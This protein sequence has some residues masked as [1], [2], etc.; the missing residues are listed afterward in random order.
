MTGV[1]TC[2]LPIFDSRSDILVYDIGNNKLLTSSLISTESSFETFPAF[3]PDGNNLLFCSAPRGN[4]PDDYDKIRYSLCRIAFDASTGSFGDQIDTLVSSHLTGKSVS[5]PRVSPDGRFIVF[6]LSDYGNF[7]IWH[8]E[9][10][11]I[12]FD[13]QTGTWTPIDVINSDDTESYHSW[14]SGSRWM[15]FSSRRLDGLYTRPYITYV[16]EEGNFGKPFLLPQKDPEYYETELRSFNVPEF[17]KSKV[18][19]NGRSMLKTIG[20]SGKNVTFELKD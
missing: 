11:L 4:Q 2:A 14:A 20:S 3:T 8:R 6:T 5:F 12:K 1:Q 13:L 9:A 17:V 16:D 19:Y 18:E 7:S 10:D 15:V